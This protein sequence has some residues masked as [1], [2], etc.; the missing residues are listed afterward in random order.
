MDS[1]KILDSIKSLMTSILESSTEELVLVK[2]NKDSIYINLGNRI[3]NSN[4]LIIS[5]TNGY[6]IISKDTIR[7]AIDEIDKAKVLTRNDTYLQLRPHVGYYDYRLYRRN[8]CIHKGRIKYYTTNSFFMTHAIL[9]SR[10]LGSQ[11]EKRRIR[12]GTS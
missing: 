3:I 1:F 9:L 10:L 5:F 12:N 6:S 8:K 4:N 2:A 11:R 7:K